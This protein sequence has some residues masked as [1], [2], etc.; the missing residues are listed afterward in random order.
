MAHL[1]ASLKPVTSVET[2]PL[3]QALGRVLAGDATALRSHPPHANAAVDG[4]GFA[5]GP[6]GSFELLE[7]RAAAGA[8]YEGDVPK[9]A[10][11]RILTGAKP[12]NGV[13]TVVLE[14]D[15]R[16]HAGQVSFEAGLK[17]GANIRA[18]GEDVSAGDVL[19][20]AGRVLTAGD[21]AMLASTGVAHLDVHMRL[22]VAVLSTGSEVVEVG[23]PAKDTQIF[24]ANRP[25]LKALLRQWQV[26]VIDLGT[27]PDDRASVVADLDRGA[28]EADVILTSGGASAGDE[29]HISASLKAAGALETWRV[30]IKPG[31]PLAMGF[32]H[33]TPLFGLPGNPVAAF[34]CTLVFAKPALGLLS[35]APWHVPVGSPLEAQFS[36]AKKPGREEYLRARR[37]GNGVEVFASE[38]SGR[39]SGLSW[40]DG[41]VALEH[42]RGP[43]KPGDLVRYI[44]FSEWGL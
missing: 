18:A 26:D 10:A 3:D 42:D 27:V 33:G 8:P 37:H 24:D 11:I 29:D 13:D 36:K 4:Y 5:H 30:A 34:V 28:Q 40:A 15:V 9:G 17:K 20:G 41:L 2:V 19:L 38:G 23:S 44:P 43:I 6:Q 12:P 22:K 35:G 16:L 14:E 25:M 1:E 31:R 7:G 32:W 39:V 21:V